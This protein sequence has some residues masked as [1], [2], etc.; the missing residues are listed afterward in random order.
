MTANPLTAQAVADLVG[1]RLS[2]P[3]DVLLRGVRSLERADPDALAMCATA[4]YADAMAR[5]RAGAVLVTDAFAVGA[6]PATRIVVTNP[7]QAMFVATRALHAEDA[8]AAGIAPTARIGRGSTFGPEATIGEY[9]VLGAGARIGARARIGCHVV[10]GDDVTIGD[11]VRLDANVVVYRDVTLGDR[12]WCKASAVIGGTGFGF[13]SDAAGHQ[14]ILHVGGCTIGDD[15][16][17]GSGTCIDRGSLDDTIIGAGTKL[18]NLVHIGHNAHLGAACLVM[19][20]VGVAG[21]TH[22]GD[23]VI[24]A[25]G[26]GLIDNLEIGNDARIGARAVVISDV[27]DGASYSGYPARPHRDFLRSIATM[28][29]LA[30][31]GK[32]LE[33]LAKE[34]GDG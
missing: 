33:S 22:V 16:E 32:A 13:V 18:D 7:A 1:G 26:S 17:I 8:V 29:Q 30:P 27:P 15:V 2:G 20:Y 6:G 31:H 4:K 28:Y 25:G 24:L 23:R 34:R 9:A 5:T 21:S 11:D 10:I 19:A 14:R 12:V 3:G